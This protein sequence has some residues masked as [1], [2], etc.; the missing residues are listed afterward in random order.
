MGNK[1][2]GEYYYQVKNIEYFMRSYRFLN[3][4]VANNVL[5]RLWHLFC[6]DIT[7][8][9]KLLVEVCRFSFTFLSPGGAAHWQYESGKFRMVSEETFLGE[10]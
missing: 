7:Q 8:I 2:A 9:D 5:L 6:P 3:D 10:G 4:R 1:G